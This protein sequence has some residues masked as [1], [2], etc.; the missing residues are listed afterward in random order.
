MN[1]RFIYFSLVM[2]SISLFLEFT[3]ID[4]FRLSDDGFL[5]IDNLVKQNSGARKQQ[6][7]L[8]DLK[9][10]REINLPVNEPCLHL[11]Y[12][13]SELKYRL[14]EHYLDQFPDS[15]KEIPFP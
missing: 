11:S 8:I 4:N 9:K 15:W 3:H 5:Y 1:V 14:R 13:S 7:R 12:T 6:I 10:N 2:K